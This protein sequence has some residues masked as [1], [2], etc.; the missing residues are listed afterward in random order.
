MGTEPVPMFSVPLSVLV[1]LEG[2]EHSGHEVGIVDGGDPD[3][4]AD[5]VRLRAELAAPVHWGPRDQ[6]V[7][8]V[9]PVLVWKDLID[10]HS[11][12][13]V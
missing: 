3:G 10:V 12:V 5:V 13:S 1:L 8:R 11:E 6:L 4:P 7:S 9:L 2:V